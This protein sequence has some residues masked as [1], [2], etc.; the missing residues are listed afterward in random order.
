M[1][2]RFVHDIFESWTPK[3]AQDSGQEK[4]LALPA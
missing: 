1:P 4:N 2:Q 3:G